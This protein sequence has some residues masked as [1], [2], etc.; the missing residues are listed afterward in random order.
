MAL[1]LQNDVMKVL[2]RILETNLHETMDLPSA[3]DFNTSPCVTKLPVMIQ[4]TSFKIIN[5]TVI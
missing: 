2:Q 1:V 5:D 4:L 3:V